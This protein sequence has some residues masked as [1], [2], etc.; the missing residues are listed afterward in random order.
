MPSSTVAATFKVLLGR[1]PGQLVI[2]TT[3]YCNGNCP[4]CGMKK[5]AKI[6]RYRLPAEKI[7]TVLEQC[8]QHGFEAVS[9]TGGE[10]FVNIRE[11]FDALDYAGNTGIR[12]LRTGTNGFMFAPD[13]KSA[14]MEQ[15]T[16]FVMRLSATKVR[17]FWISIDSADTQVHETMR[18]LPGVIE[19]IQKALPVF[20]AHGIYPAAN[21]GINRNIL[22]KPIERLSGTH[23]ED[24]FLR[25][26]SA[27]FTAFLHK[28]IQMGFTMANVCYPMSSANKY[29]ENPAYGAIS[30]DFIVSFSPREL[31]LI[32]QAL[33]DVIPN[34][35][36][37]IRIFTPL[38]LLYAMSRND[39]TL[40][41]PCLGGI[42]YFYMDSRD[43]HIYPCGYRG[44]EDLGEELEVAVRQVRGVKPDCV[45]CHWEC[46]R[47]PS[48]LF[49]IGRYMLRHPIRTFVQ[50]Q[51]DPIMRK[52]WFEDIQY[53]I[54]CN[55]FDGR[56]APKALLSARTTD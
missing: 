31:Q 45:K 41:F 26:F 13:G 33:F 8:T 53:Y 42:R 35:R 48:Q 11:L 38:S 29:L 46:F 17:N 20:H 6:E 55:L 51:I 1:I 32:F 30:E 37:K 3:N 23:D 47:D 22:G 9:F 10:P 19:G 43:G 15:I 54:R 52:L 34:F 50:W 39:P 18:G 40:L 14:D 12:Y 5:T 27:G 16:D 21:L 28:V 4:Q 24:R 7:R 44:N 56:T 49:G 25:E 36:D 2:Q